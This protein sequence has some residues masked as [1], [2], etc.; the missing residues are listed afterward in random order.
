MTLEGVIRDAKGLFQSRDAL[1]DD[2]LYAHEFVDICID[3]LTASIRAKYVTPQDAKVIARGFS[4]DIDHLIGEHP[5]RFRE[6]RVVKQDAAQRKREIHDSVRKTIGYTWELQSRLRRLY[7]DDATFDYEHIPEHPGTIISEPVRLSARARE[8]Y[9]FA[10]EL[11]RAIP[12]EK[13]APVAK[14]RDSPDDWYQSESYKKSTKAGA[15]ALLTGSLVCY[16][17]FGAAILGHYLE[18]KG[19][20]VT[21][22]YGSVLGTAAL[23][24]GMN[25]YHAWRKAHPAAVPA[26]PIMAPAGTFSA[27][28]G[29]S[30]LSLCAVLSM[31]SGDVSAQDRE[32][33][34][35]HKARALVEQAASS[36]FL[37]PD[38]VPLELYRK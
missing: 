4:S 23:G 38:E 33:A 16:G 30:V 15:K 6:W 5:L 13:Q 14:P 31:M 36:S 7:P 34:K 37:F 8:I 25:K 22:L 29:A 18:Q 26:E 12:A 21:A 32:L 20:N 3:W 27:R 1:W 28:I 10:Q 17:M 11:Q 35:P 9:R 19:V 2:Y 24:H